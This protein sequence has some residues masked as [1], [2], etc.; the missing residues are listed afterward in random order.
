MRTAKPSKASFRLTS[1]VTKGGWITNGHYAVHASVCA[2]YKDRAL[3]LPEAEAFQIATEL[4]SEEMT[5]VNADGSPELI[6]TRGP[7]VLADSEVEALIPKKLEPAR[8]AH[9]SIPPWRFQESGDISLTPLVSD[10]VCLAW[11]NAAYLIEIGVQPGD[12]VYLD[13]EKPGIGCVVDEKSDARRIIMPVNT[14]VFTR[15]IHVD[16]LGKVIADW[17]AP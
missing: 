2:N 10:G 7:L 5:R 8:V 6:I 17:A 16:E 4:M 13:A 3:P 14:S 9:F 1:Y 11:M 15:S 12:E